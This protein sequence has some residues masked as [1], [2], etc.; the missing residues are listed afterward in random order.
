[1]DKPK[2]DKEEVT[3]NATLPLQTFFFPPQDGR[4]A[5]TCEAE[6]QTDA[7]TQYIVALGQS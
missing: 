5:F 4:E 1:M 7:D 2:Q 6:N 3:K